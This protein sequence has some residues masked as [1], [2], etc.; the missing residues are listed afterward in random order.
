MN[1]LWHQNFDP[2]G[3]PLLSTLAVKDAI[4]HL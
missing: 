3:N 4:A 1:Q 2:L